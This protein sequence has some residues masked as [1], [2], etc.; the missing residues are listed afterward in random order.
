[1]AGEFDPD[2]FLDVDPVEFQRRCEQAWRVLPEAEVRARF[3]DARA[4]AKGVAAIPIGARLP[5]VALSDWQGEPPLRQSL[6]G[7]WLPVRQTTMLTGAGGIG[8]SL[9]AQN[10]LA[11][12]ALGLPFLGMQTVRSRSLCVTCE[13]DADELWRRLDA[14]CSARGRTISELAGWLH[15]VTLSGETDTALAT[16]S[17][18]GG[19]QTTERWDQLRGTM[20]EHAIRLAVFDNATDAMAGDHNDIH[21][22]ASFVN[23]LTGQAQRSDGV[24]GIL[25]HPNKAG[26][27]WLGSVAWHNKVRSRLIIE[28]CAGPDPDIR[29]IKNPKANYG[30]Q[31]GS[32]TF[33]WHQG[34]FIQDDDL[35]DEYLKRMAESTVA[36]A[37]NL[38]FLNCLRECTRR[39]QGVSASPS[40]TYAPSVFAEMPEAKGRTRKELTGAL[41]RLLTLQAIE[42]G[43]LPWLRSDRHKA[44][45][46]REVAGN[47][48]GN[49]RQTHAG[50]AGDAAD[51]GNQPIEKV[52]GER[53]ADWRQ[54]NPSLTE[55]D[56]APLGQAASPAEAFADDDLD[57]QG[58]DHDPFD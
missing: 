17:R 10:L 55:R 49:A 33:R 53:E 34:A 42:T 15:I 39:Q 38:I 56:A 14:F 40:P 37:G 46:L 58:E 44:M 20:E 43:E 22:V 24:F 11:S 6:W 4:E 57:W 29:T 31:G 26:D 3:D 25:H 50:D 13:D 28:G 30:P 41:N 45:G 2:D 35:A 8:K 32:I 19:L 47:A 12:V 54:R 16:V 1:M 27:D 23:L 36:A 5:E 9:F 51:S 48:A 7:T 18:D 21:Q 52:S